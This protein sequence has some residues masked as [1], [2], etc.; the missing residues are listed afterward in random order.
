MVLV[1]EPV[2][3]KAI[4]CIEGKMRDILTVSQDQKF[5]VAD[6]VVPIDPDHSIYNRILLEQFGSD[7][8]LNIQSA[9]MPA[10]DR[11]Y[12]IINAF[13]HDLTDL[14][15]KQ[16]MSGGVSASGSILDAGPSSNPRVYKVLVSINPVK[17][18]TG[19]PV[20]CDGVAR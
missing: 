20:S 4:F 17:S 15:F 12:N 7:L 9:W 3:A 14:N 18:A 11:G 13:F 19:F 10:N 6:W 1:T 2:T 8:H 5:A 16:E